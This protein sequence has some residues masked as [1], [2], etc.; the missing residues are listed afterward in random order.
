M[1]SKG[2]QFNVGSRKV[3]SGHHD[4]IPCI[5]FSTDGTKLVSCSI[6][7]QCIVWDVLNGYAIARFSNREWNWSCL[8]ISIADIKQIAKDDEVWNTDFGSPRSSSAFDN[9]M[10][11]SIINNRMGVDIEIHPESSYEGDQDIAETETIDH[12]G[13]RVFDESES[14]FNTSDNMF[15]CF[16][17]SYD[18]EHFLSETVLSKKPLSNME[19]E[20]NSYLYQ[21]SLVILGCQHDISLFDYESHDMLSGFRNMFSGNSAYAHRSAFERLSVLKWIRELSLVIVGCQ[22]GKVGMVRLLKSEEK[23][24]M[25]TDTFVIARLLNHGSHQLQVRFQFLVCPVSNYQM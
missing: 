22:S 24:K 15:D 2:D 12:P 18:S 4:N 10:E 11:E 9:L 23:V 6:D 14:D 5:N 20:V 1:T 17:I 19:N 21:E 8:F 13:L 16:D 3:L 25:V 7:K